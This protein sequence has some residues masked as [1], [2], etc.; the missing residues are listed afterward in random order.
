MN[1]GGESGH[2]EGREY[3]FKMD[4]R[5]I[6]REDVNWMNW[7]EIVSSDELCR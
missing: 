3:N 4:L 7:L 1:F 5:R 6:G 2:L